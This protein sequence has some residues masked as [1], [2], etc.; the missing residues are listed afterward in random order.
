[1][2]MAVKALWEGLFSAKANTSYLPPKDQISISPK[3]LKRL[4][5]LTVHAL[6]ACE[7]AFKDSNCPHPPEKTGCFA[8]IHYGGWQSFE[9][10]LGNFK[11]TGYKG[12]RPATVLAALQVA[13][14]GNASA[15]FQILGDCKTF[16]SGTASSAHALYHA[17]Q[18]IQT[19]ELEASLSVVQS[20]PSLP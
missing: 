15:L 4:D 16:S 2:D 8:G 14:Q 20:F 10:L 17:Y 13:T 18:L 7:L 5:P 6:H 19:G 11:K 9:T 1:M 3:I 12:I